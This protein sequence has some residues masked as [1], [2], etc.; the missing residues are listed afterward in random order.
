MNQNWV[1][2]SR[3]CIASLNTQRRS[4]KCTHPDEVCRSNS[5][6]RCLCVKH[7]EPFHD[8]VNPGSFGACEVAPAQWG[9]YCLSSAG[10]KWDLVTSMRLMSATSTGWRPTSPSSRCGTAG[11]CAKAPWCPCAMAA[12]LWALHRRSA[13]PVGPPHI[14]HQHDVSC[15][16]LRRSGWSA[17]GAARG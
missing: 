10:T 7:E 13:V 11:A 15:L 8:A 5:R 4:H 16:Y 3:G 12:R 14:A 9:H 1:H 6:S 2:I 17:S